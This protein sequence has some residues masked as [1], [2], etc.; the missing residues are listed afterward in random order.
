MIHYDRILQTGLQSLGAVGAGWGCGSAGLL[1]PGPTVVHVNALVLKFCIPCLQVWLLAIKTDMREPGNWRALGMFLAWSVALQALLA[2]RQL[3]TGR[4]LQL[5]Q[6]GVDSLILTT[7]NT[8]ILGPVVLEAAVGPRYAPLGMLATVVLYF[9][10]LPSAQLLFHL[11]KQQRAAAAAAAGGGGDGEAAPLRA[12]HE[13]E[14]AQQRQQAAEQRGMDKAGGRGHASPPAEAN[15]GGGSDGSS[16]S[17]SPARGPRQLQSQRHGSADSLQCQQ[18]AA[19]TAAGDAQQPAGSLGVVAS[20]LLKNPLVWT[21]G[22]SLALSALGSSAL[23]DPRSPAAL[24]QLAFLEQLLSWFG[25]ATAPLTL[26]TTGLWM[27]DNA[28]QRRQQGQH[29]LQQQH[30]LQQ[31]QGRQGLAPP[32]QGGGGGA[33][34]RPPSWARLLGC[35]AARGVLAPAAM[36]ALAWALG[37]RGDLAA[38]LV[39]LALLPVAQTAFV[40]AQDAGVGAADQ[41]LSAAAAPAHGRSSDEGAHAARPGPAMA[42]SALTAALGALL[43]AACAVAAAS[44]AAAPPPL[45]GTFIELG[46]GG[47]TF[48]S[49]LT[50]RCV[51]SVKVQVSGDPGFAGVLQMDVE[52]KP[53]PGLTSTAALVW[54]YQ[55]L[56]LGEVYEFEQGGKKYS[57]TL[58]LQ[59]HPVDHVTAAAYPPEGELPGPGTRADWMETPVYDCTYNAAAATRPWAC[60]RTRTGPVRSTPPERWGN[61]GPHTRVSST[62]SQLDDKALATFVTRS[63]YVL[64]MYYTKNVSSLRHAWRSTP[65]GVVITTRLTLGIFK[66]GGTDELDTTFVGQTGAPKIKAGLLDGLR[67]GLDLRA[68]GAAMAVHAVQE[69]RRLAEWLPAAY[70]RY[71]AAAGRSARPR[72]RA[73]AGGA[74]ERADLVERVT[75]TLPLSGVPVWPDKAGDGA[76][77]SSAPASAPGAPAGAAWRKKQRRVKIGLPGHKVVTMG[78]LIVGAVGAWGAALLLFLAWWRPSL[79]MTGGATGLGLAAGVLYSFLYFGNCRAK[80]QQQQVLSMDPGLKG[81]QFLLG[82]LPSWINKTDREKMEWLNKLLVEVWP[83]YDRGVCKAVREVVEPIMEAYRP[84]IFKR[85][86]FEEL[87][88]G[89]APVRIEGI[90][91]KDTGDEIDLEVDVRWSGDANISLGIDL[92]LGGEFTRLT[93]KVKDIVF[94][95]T[96]KVILKPLVEAIPGFAAAAVALKTVPII[97]YRLDFGVL[98]AGAS[99]IVTVPIVSF[100]DMIVQQV[101]VGM[102]LWPKRVTVPILSWDGV[103]PVDDPAVDLE[104]ERLNGR[105]QGVIKVHVICAKELN[106]YD[107]M[108]KSDPFV[109]IFTT[110]DYRAAT[111]VISNNLAPVWDEVKYLPVLEKDTVLRLECFD[112]DPVNV[113]SLA[114]LKDVASL[115]GSKEFMGRSAI[116]LSQFISEEGLEDEFWV[117]LGRGEWT[118]LGGPGQ[119]EGWVKLGLQYRAVENIAGEEI[120]SATRGLLLVGVI[121]GHDLGGPGAN[122]KLTNFVSVKLTG[123]KGSKPQTHKTPPLKSNAPRWS[124]DNKFTLYDVNNTDTL[125]VS[126][127]LPGL[128]LDDT[129]GSL[130][131]AVSDIIASR[132]VSR[133][134]GAEQAG[135]VHETYP[136]GAGGSQGRLEL[137][138]EFLP[139]W[140]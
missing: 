52:H 115:K 8:G 87:T 62:L 99:Q 78:Q 125:E 104:V 112:Y 4:R 34:E 120:L 111:R 55:H 132:Q 6:L 11:D 1:A 7:N 136:L 37:V 57:T 48:C 38:A 17:W 113:T 109:E 107:S 89:E 131:L 118:N 50:S 13:Q 92:P 19:A 73:P 138:I 53:I 86:F 21:T 40:V 134:T 45:N 93:P 79:G 65:R 33:A 97:K 24:A 31:Q 27:Y 47:W 121:R 123:G 139:Y 71:G 98:P 88:F 106:S 81:C 77:S 100:V 91:V 75:S 135:Y 14:L 60:K 25:S 39:I 85:I 15:G 59:M 101:I 114:G 127:V 102:L 51:K 30:G 119:G 44:A 10:Q 29:R 124:R 129:L 68:V 83:Y 133:W 72:D 32:Q 130:T 90:F 49:D 64:G 110:D 103:M 67:P 69:V 54:L 16:P 116:P 137:E 94:V 5:A 126:V 18:P 76:G 82:R 46:A 26:F 20:L 22:A 58:F 140:A 23:L 128:A 96:L 36:A 80:L 95:A 12:W 9:Q 105:Q 74:M 61:D 117:P 108:G 41:R 43:V 2:L 35:L 122:D 42:R 84:P 28:A 56:P 66:S 3:A 63:E 70:A